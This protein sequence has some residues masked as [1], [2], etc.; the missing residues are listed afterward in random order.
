MWRTPTGTRSIAGA[1]A[2]L[3]RATI[4]VMLDDLLAERECEDVAGMQTRYRVEAFDDLPLMSRLGLLHDVAQAL[5]RSDVPPPRLTAV[6][7]ATLAAIINQVEQLI[8]LEIDAQD[9]AVE[10]VPRDPCMWR[11]WLLACNAAAED[12]PVPE[13]DAFEKTA[14]TSPDHDDWQLEVE[15]L[16][17]RFL[18]DVDF[19]YTDIPDLPPEQ[20]AAECRALG[21]EPD[22]YTALPP[23]PRED[24]FDAL[25]DRL[26]ALCGGTP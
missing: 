22:Y 7:E 25:V 18:W 6:H 23:D 19:E 8:W 9:V 26:R 17:E 10:E 3:F 1:E 16:A 13:D 5:L 11:G 12:S 2:V 4:A 21:I 20:A 15:M 14:V 24:E